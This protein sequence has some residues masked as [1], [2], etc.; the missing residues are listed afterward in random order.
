MLQQKTTL[1][2]EIWKNGKNYIF[3]KIRTLHTNG[4]SLNLE[5]RRMCC[6]NI[7]VENL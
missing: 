1:L 6:R 4:L 7:Q 2:E 3:M 5:N